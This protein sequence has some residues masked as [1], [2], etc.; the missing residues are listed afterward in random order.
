MLSWLKCLKELACWT[1]PCFQE[2]HR[3]MESLVLYSAELSG[4]RVCSWLLAQQVLAIMSLLPWLFCDRVW[5]V[6]AVLRFYCPC[7]WLHWLAF[8]TI[9]SVVSHY[10]WICWRLARPTESKREQWMWTQALFL[11][12]DTFTWLPSL[13]TILWTKNISLFLQVPDSTKNLTD[14]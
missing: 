6:A 7:N 8:L 14:L 5:I 12:Q 1:A 11:T 4:L 10:P 13:Y 9:W 3:T 2:N